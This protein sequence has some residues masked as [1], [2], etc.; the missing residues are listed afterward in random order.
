MSFL[1]KIGRALDPTRKKG[2][3]Q[4]AGR[5]IVKAAPIVAPFIPGLGIP[6]SIAIGAASGALSK[7][8]NVVGG[9]LKGAVGG[10]ANKALLG[11]RGILGVPGALGKVK[12]LLVG[13]SATAG[14][15]ATPAEATA[16]GIPGLPALPA[17]PGQAASGG[18]LGALGDYFRRD[19]GQAIQTGL[20]VLGTAQG[21]QRAGQANRLRSQALA[22]LPVAGPRPDLS[23]AFANPGNPYALPASGGALQ[24]ARASLR[25]Y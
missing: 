7:G 6:A 16:P 21:A 5:A 22:G 25:G 18:I 17:V 12:N 23:G 4:T 10:V 13:H 11:G 19:P 20:G 15:A 2:L 24:A 3:L 9:A 1:G 8:H 14:Q